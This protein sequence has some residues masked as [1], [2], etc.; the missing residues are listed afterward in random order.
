MNTSRVNGQYEVLSPWAEAD[1]IPL[2][3]LTP[4]VTNL[5]GKKIGLYQ[6]GKR[7][8]GPIIS[9]VEQRLMARFPTLKF[10]PFRPNL[11][12]AS[13]DV[14]EPEKTDKFGDWVNEVDTV[15]LAVGD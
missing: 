4:R 9:V 14:T 12:P 15:I 5:E 3:G 7:A 10:L 2:R 13:A 11:S 8:A 1:P 6:N